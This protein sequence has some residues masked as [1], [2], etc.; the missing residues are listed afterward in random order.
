MK[1]STVAWTLTALIGIAGLVG[2]VYT[3]TS[4]GTYQPQDTG[5]YQVA[6]APIGTT[7]ISTSTVPAAFPAST[8]ASTTLKVQ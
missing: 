6:T 8:T 1:I 3:N 4:Q 5:S 2:Y 7:T